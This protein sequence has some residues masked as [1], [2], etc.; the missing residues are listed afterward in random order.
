MRRHDNK[1]G[2]HH[3]NFSRK[4]FGSP[5]ILDNHRKT[6]SGSLKFLKDNVFLVI[7]GS[8]YIVLKHFV[9]YCVY[10]INRMHIQSLL[11]NIKLLLLD[12]HLIKE[13]ICKPWYSVILIDRSTVVLKKALFSNLSVYY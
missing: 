6:R 13:Y 9:K 7:V 8:F 10:Q 5:S 2:K 4:W 3:T 1:H 12:R 11:I